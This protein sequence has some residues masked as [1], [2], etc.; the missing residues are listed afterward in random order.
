LKKG[1][2]P[3]PDLVLIDGGKGQV[4][5]SRAALMELQLGDLAL[6]G[7]AKGPGRR[8]GRETIYKGGN[9]A[10]LKLA[11]DTPAMHLIQQIRDEAHRFAISGHRNRRSKAR[12]SSV[13]ETINGLGPKRRRELLRHFGG[14][15]GIR[16]AGIDDLVQ[17]PGVSRI[18][19]EKIYDRFHG[20]AAVDS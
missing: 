10:R 12:K 2:A 20:G 7:I 13:L 4:G 14:L 18:L 1:E 6:A 11:P 9:N 3:L 16:R 15:Q 19:A 8:P 17:V 5:A